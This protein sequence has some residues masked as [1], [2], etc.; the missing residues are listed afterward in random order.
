M[1][2]ICIF[3]DSISWGSWDPSG[4]GWANRLR[5]VG[6]N[7]LD[8]SE[9]DHDWDYAAVYNCGICGDKLADVLRRFDVEAEARQPTVVILAIG[10]NDI[11]H[12]DHRGT[13]PDDFARGY[14]ELIAK[15]KRFTQDVI[16]VTPT[17]VDEARSEHDYRNA[18]ISALA[19]VVE[20]CA[21]DAGL[22]LVKAFG[23][24]TP[25]D[26]HPD[27]LHPGPAGHEKLFRAIEPVVFGLSAL[28]G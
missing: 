12:G 17:N 2:R 8:L 3:G 28:G 26:L 10:I 21:G 14:V 24:L 16:L 27:G 15:A 9:P 22:P 23:T 11:P 1:A 5:E 25:E 4:G 6:C 19:E 7:R 13:P 18:D 20:K